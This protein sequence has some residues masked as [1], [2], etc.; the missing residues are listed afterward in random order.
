MNAAVH[1]VNK[2][3]KAF[4]FQSCGCVEKKIAPAAIGNFV[5]VYE[6]GPMCLQAIIFCVS[7]RGKVLCSVPIS[8]FG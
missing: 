3:T 6:C 1:T 5:C 7:E 8:P 4:D 2:L